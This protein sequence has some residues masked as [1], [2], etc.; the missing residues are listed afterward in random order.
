MATVTEYSVVA[1]FVENGNLFDR[2]EVET[3]ERAEQMAWE[4]NEAEPRPNIFHGANIEVRW[5]V[6]SRVV[7]TAPDSEWAP[8]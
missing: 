8:V 3:L 1:R 7:V 6:E 4:L 2:I 5:T